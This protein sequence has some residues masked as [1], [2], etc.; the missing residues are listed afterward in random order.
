VIS[1]TKIAVALELLT[2]S[3]RHIA[4]A[5]LA[6]TEPS[7]STNWEYGAG[8]ATEPANEKLVGFHIEP[9]RAFLT[10]GMTVTHSAPSVRRLG[11]PASSDFVS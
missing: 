11:R 2:V 7:M 9:E 3:T 1:L 6:E 8:T 4:I 10:R 5:Y